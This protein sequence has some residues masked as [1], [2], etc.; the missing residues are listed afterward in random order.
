MR[1]LH[2]AETRIPQRILAD[3]E[4]D[5]AFVHGNDS[6]SNDN[7]GNPSRP[8]L[9]QDAGLNKAREDDL[10]HLVS[11]GAGDSC[12][13][14]KDGMIAAWKSHERYFVLQDPILKGEEQMAFA[15]CGPENSCRRNYKRY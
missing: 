12:S 10:M 13:W 4:V 7:D 2:E 3:L 5:L 11:S 6:G 8:T 9:P 1:Q 15:D 14:K